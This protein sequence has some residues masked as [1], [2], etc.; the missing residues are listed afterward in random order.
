[1]RLRNWQ[2]RAIETAL[3]KFESPFTHFLCLATPGAGKTVMAAALADILLKEDKVDLVLCFSPSTVVAN[4]F[5]IEL[6]GITNKRFCGGLGATGSSLTYQSMRHLDDAFWQLMISYRVFVIFDEIHHCAGR[7]IERANSWGAEILK[8]IQGKAYYTIAL[9]GTPWRSDT[10]PIVLAN[11]LGDNNQ[12]HV[13]YRY[14]LKQ[15]ISDGV[16]RFPHL[17]LLDNELISVIEDGEKANFKSIR[18]F[19]EHSSLNY[20]ELIDHDEVVRQILKRGITQLTRERAQVYNAG[21]LIVAASVSHAKKIQSLLKELGES[22]ELVTYQENDP[23]HLIKQFKRSTQKWIISIGM[24]S[25]GTNIPRLRVCCYLSLVTTELYFRQVLGRILRAQ[26]AEKE[27]GY[28]ITPAHPRLIEF[29]SRVS[30]EVPHYALLQPS[31]TNETNKQ[32]FPSKDTLAEISVIEITKPQLS[33]KA[34]FEEVE[35]SF[36]GNLPSW[37]G[38]TIDSFG[39]FHQ[40]VLML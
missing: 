24:I 19:L 9:T 36:E 20:F 21:G 15:A 33:T 2:Q 27:I 6:E 25:E 38:S 39:R 30:E 22:S 18:D 16:C 23:E 37:Y 11:Y 17:T 29:A 13:D 3:Q 1:M 4:D 5:K 12:I 14:D 31:V 10:I 8:H 26:S 28:F 40:K 34:S 35:G 32:E 7:E